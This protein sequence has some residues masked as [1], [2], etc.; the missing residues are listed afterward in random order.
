MDSWAT[1]EVGHACLGDQRL[2]T[3]LVR[4]VTD[5]AAQPSAS[6]PQACGTPAATKAAYR[7]FDTEAVT[8]QAIQA[9]HQQTTLERLRGAPLVLAIQDTTD[10][11]FRHPPR[12]KGWVRL[13][14]L[15]RQ[16]SQS[17]P[18]WP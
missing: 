1:T 7:F 18:C 13:I 15:A 14:L 9:A 3:R 4:L 10:L 11:D 5:L 2:T 16:H 6:L 17:M 12:L 8:P